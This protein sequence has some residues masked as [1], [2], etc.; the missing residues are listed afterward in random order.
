MLSQ[1]SDFGFSEQITA[2]G[3]MVGEMGGTVTHV[4]PEVVLHKQVG[5]SLVQML[6]GYHVAV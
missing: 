6:L 1:V 3:P 5:E 2:R 4:A